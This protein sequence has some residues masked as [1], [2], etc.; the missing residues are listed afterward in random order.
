MLSSNFLLNVAAGY[1]EGTAERRKNEREVALQKQQ[2]AAKLDRE[3][4]KELANTINSKKKKKIK[5]LTLKS[6]QS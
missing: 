4:A 5:S 3:F 6:M 2:D 1:M